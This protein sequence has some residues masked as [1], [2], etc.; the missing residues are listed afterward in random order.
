M[1][2]PKDL[3]RRAQRNEKSKKRRQQKR[4]LAALTANKTVVTIAASS[5]NLT[6]TDYLQGPG[7]INQRKN[8]HIQQ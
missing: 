8:E 2:P 4:K 7:Y 1:A 3:T 5:L 6:Q